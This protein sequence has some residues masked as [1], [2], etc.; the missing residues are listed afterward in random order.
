MQIKQ[1]VSGDKDTGTGSLV[2]GV[3]EERVTVTDA[4][5]HETE[6]RRY[7]PGGRTD[8]DETEV[9]VFDLFDGESVVLT[10]EV[11]DRG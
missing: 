8:L 2:V 9:V 1:K 7:R 6:V 4:E 10:L 5:G 3:V 11:S